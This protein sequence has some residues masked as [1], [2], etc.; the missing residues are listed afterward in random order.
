MSGPSGRLEHSYAATS[1]SSPFGGYGGMGEPSATRLPAFVE[2][3]FGGYAGMG[4]PSATSV[5]AFI[6]G[7][8]GYG[9]MGDPSATSVGGY[10]GMGEPSAISV[11]SMVAH[12]PAERLT[13]RTTGSTIETARRRT[14]TAIAVFFKGVS[15][16]MNS[17]RRDSFLGP[18]SWKM[19]R[20]RNTGRHEN[21]HTAPAKPQSDSGLH[22]HN[23]CRYSRAIRPLDI[24]R[25]LVRSLQRP[26]ATCRT[27]RALSGRSHPAGFAGLP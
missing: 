25:C 23:P 27:C 7:F 2:D 26:L 1:V 15:L 4:E 12:L 14:A 16:L 8:G 24:H 22:T 6:D 17:L 19:F 21:A 13:D 20:M 11:P 5:P 18:K 9:S 10:G 3:G